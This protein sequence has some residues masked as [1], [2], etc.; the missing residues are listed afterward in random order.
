MK[1]KHYSIVYFVFVFVFI[2]K[3]ELMKSE[4]IESKITMLMNLKTNI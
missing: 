1:Q 2:V 4:K 3:D